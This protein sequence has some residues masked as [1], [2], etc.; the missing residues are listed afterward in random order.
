MLNLRQLFLVLFILV[1]HLSFG[2]R[3]LQDSLL[4]TAKSESDVFKK[5]N[6]LNEYCY[7]FRRSDREKGRRLA[8]FLFQSA[9]NV[10]SSES[11]ADYYFLRGTFSFP[12]DPD[13][14]II[15]FQEALDRYFQ[16]QIDEVKLSRALNNLAS[17]Y[18]Y[19][20]EYDSS[21][22]YS[23]MA[24]SVL[25]DVSDK[26]SKVFQYRLA[27]NYKSIADAY[28]FNT[29]LDCSIV[30]YA[31]GE[32]YSRLCRDSNS[33]AI[34][35]NNK[36]NVLNLNE[37]YLEATEILLEV[38]HLHKILG[39]TSELINSYS[40]IATYFAFA[41]KNEIARAYIDSA[42]RLSAEHEIER[43]LPANYLGLGTIHF[44]NGEYIQ[45]IEKSKEGLKIAR[46]I[47]NYFM[48]KALLLLLGESALELKNYLSAVDYFKQALNCKDQFLEHDMLA[49][50]GLA[51]AYEQLNDH[52]NALKYS[53]Q[54][55][56][57]KDSI[58]NLKKNLIINQ[59][60]RDSK[61][62]NN[63][64]TI[65]KLKE[66]K[67]KVYSLRNKEFS[68]KLI[69]ISILGLFLVIAFLYFK[70]YKLK[71]DKEKEASVINERLRISRDLHDD[72][73]ATI[74][75]INIY[76]SAVK[77]KLKE[78]KIEETEKILDKIS[79][80]AQDMV[81]GMSDMVWTISPD[82]DTIEKLINRIHNYGTDIMQAKDIQFKLDYD[83]QVGQI[84]L[85]LEQRRNVFLILKEAIN[86]LVKYANT[87]SA[88]LKA[89]IVNNKIYIELSDSGI[90]FD[91]SLIRNTH[92]GGNGLKN[93][94][95]RAAEIH[96]EA[97]IISS[98]GNG[99]TVRLIIS[100]TKNG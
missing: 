23:L 12:S 59:V 29:L 42:M 96:A 62:I 31:R 43:Y 69:V 95:Q 88:K 99:T 89:C 70:F 49:N 17:V 79:E 15:F 98:P 68:Q 74:S 52:T 46:E 35:L 100:P 90:G 39:N 11:I 44:N 27:I 67:D 92:N 3:A 4:K 22:K 86:N 40:N 24:N 8:D 2:Q 54:Y 6:I 77:Q 66:D 10:N 85:T 28:C 13:S 93:M 81:Y 87:D 56:A 53:N 58:Y 84:K 25:R 71:K 5:L 82:N 18:H 33:L 7:S 61:V 9:L 80:E 45:A 34:C 38:I 55:H 16:L 76:S 21:L 73:G 60:S 91:S 97:L 50:K 51:F 48:E 64:N 14:T 75:S 57:Q 32:H 72:L 63:E 1:N 37:Q 19:Q 20:S 78:N 94:Q 26:N 41:K 47:E 83:A 36:A 65:Q 30:N